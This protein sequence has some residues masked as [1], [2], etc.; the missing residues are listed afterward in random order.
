MFDSL[1]PTAYSLQPAA[2]PEDRLLLL[3]CRGR[4]S[5][6]QEAEARELLLQPSA[7]CL[8]PS[9]FRLPP[10]AFRL[11]PSAF[12]LLPSAFCL[13]PSA[14]RLPPSAF[15]L[16]PS[17][18]DWSR[19]LALALEQEILP[20]FRR[21]LET[22]GFPG[23]PADARARMNALCRANT[24]RQMFLVEELRRLLGLLDSAGIP[25]IP[26]KGPWLAQRLYGDYTLRVCADLDLMVP[27]DRA[28][29]AARVL[30]ADGYEGC[31]PLDFFARHLVPGSMDYCL[32]KR[33]SLRCAVE[34]HWRLLRDGA[35][36]RRATDDFWNEAR[37]CTVFGAPAYCLTPEWE[38]LFLSLHA[39][40][41]QWQGLKWLVDIDQ[42][43][44]A[45]AIDWDR[46]KAKA[47]EFGFTP[48]V[49][50]TLGAC[51][52]VFGTAVPK[53]F[54]AGWLPAGVRLFPAPAPA[55]SALRG[56]MVHYRLLRGVW[57]KL[58]C[59]A[60]LCFVPTLAERILVPLP[61]SFSFL[62]YLVRPLRLSCKWAWRL[63]RGSLFRNRWLELRPEPKCVRPAALELGVQ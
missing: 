24:A 53:P 61:S 15:C 34:L 28:V 37:P 35:S 47:D 57:E 16:P 9:A 11:L 40:T 2:C 8:P 5:A 6:E 38:L 4:V 19:L 45:Q 12:R 52:Q 55:F 51:H 13:P 49:E 23:V 18:L 59:L 44:S 10:S 3:L 26:L 1:Q 60:E 48:V 36:D 43:C 29:D 17:A 25:A 46:A 14:F 27:P 32:S 63:L 30:T 42:I 39:A 22:L 31:F 7:F 41:H 21:N 33:G 50:H 58:R 56:A 54:A 20:L 62:Y